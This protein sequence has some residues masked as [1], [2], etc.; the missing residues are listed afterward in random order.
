MPRHI[1]GLP[2]RDASIGSAHNLEKHDVSSEFD[3]SK[4]S[5][6]C[7]GLWSTADMMQARPPTAANS[8]CNPGE[9][10]FRGEIGSDAAHSLPFAFRLV[11]V[12]RTGRR[13][14]QLE[15]DLIR[16]VAQNPRTSL[17]SSSKLYLN[18][19]VL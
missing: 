5:R 12:P 1:A 9:A 11:P 6:F 19:T 8:H 10:T 2:K 16:R 13:G 14:D 17:S 18:V 15:P 3:E 7:E 4:V